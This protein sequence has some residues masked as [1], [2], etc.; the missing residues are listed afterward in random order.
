MKNWCLRI[1]VLE[2]TLESPLVWKI[3]P[4]NLKGNPPWIF[5]RRTIA[6]A[7][8][9]RLRPPDVK[10][11]LFGKNPDAR[12]DWRQ[13][14]RRQQRMRWLDTIT[15]SK[16]I[17]LSKLWEIVEDREAWHAVVCEVSK[18]WIWLSTWTTTNLTSIHA[19]ALWICK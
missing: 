19:V 14:T 16:D 11:Q 9:P 18:H 6:E 13:K 2:K 17:N 5:I 12:K 8:V 15:G 10:S 4:F 7:E 3:K 1:V